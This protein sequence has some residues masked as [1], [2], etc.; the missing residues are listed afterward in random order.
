MTTENPDIYNQRSRRRSRRTRKKRSLIYNIFK[1]AKKNPT[2]IIALLFAIVL[3]YITILFIQYASKHKRRNA[4]TLRIE[5]KQ[6]SSRYD[7]LVAY[8]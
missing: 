5:M 8:E 6:Y 4:T 1:W 7:E 2:K 3:I